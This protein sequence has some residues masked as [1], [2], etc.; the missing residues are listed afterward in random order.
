[1]RDAIQQ[2]AHQGRTWC[3]AL[4]E[5]FYITSVCGRC[6]AARERL[7]GECARQVWRWT[8]SVPDA[9]LEWTQEVTP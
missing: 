2:K 6:N 5:G 9:R 7:C 4:G 3:L 1:M 8:L